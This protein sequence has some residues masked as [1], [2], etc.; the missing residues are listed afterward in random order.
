MQT[1]YGDLEHIQVFQPFLQRKSF[2]T[3]CLLSWT[4]QPFQRGLT[5]AHLGA[6]FFVFN[7][8]AL[9]KAKIVYNFDLSECNRVNRVDC[10]KK[11]GKNQNGRVD[12]PECVSIH[13]KRT[14]A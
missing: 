10:H 8:I 14:T 4:K 5:V 13:L 7:P 9:R 12:T 1:C 2:V 6:D 11:G 3:T